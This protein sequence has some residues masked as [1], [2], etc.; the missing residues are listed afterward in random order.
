MH[1]S[2]NAQPTNESPKSRE[3]SISDSMRASMLYSIV[4]INL[5]QAKY[6]QRSSNQ[7]SIVASS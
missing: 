4:G 7:L 6:V 1:R 2:A 5:R 3:M